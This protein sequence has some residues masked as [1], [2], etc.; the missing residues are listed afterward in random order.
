MKLNNKEKEELIDYLK[1]H[2]KIAE[3]LIESDELFWIKDNEEREEYL[4]F[5]LELK[6]K[7]ETLE[8][9]KEIEIDIPL[10]YNDEDIKFASAFGYMIISKLFDYNNED[11]IKYIRPVDGVVN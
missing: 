4:Q 8:N 10:F 11:Y 3:E 7:C 5:V 2:Y 1:W 6:E 9:Q